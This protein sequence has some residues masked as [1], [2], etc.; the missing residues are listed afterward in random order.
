MD[1]VHA[2]QK[3]GMVYGTESGYLKVKNT[4]MNGGYAGYGGSIYLENVW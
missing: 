1:D 3:G 2:S 4:R